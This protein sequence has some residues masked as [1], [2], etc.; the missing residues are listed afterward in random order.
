MVL[1]HVL[2]KKREGLFALFLVAFKTSWLYGVD[3]E[4]LVT[5]KLSGEGIDR[6]PEK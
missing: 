5:L 3:G 4:I 6:Q 2:T 1:V